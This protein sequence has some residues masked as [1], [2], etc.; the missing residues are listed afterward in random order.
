MK[1]ETPNISDAEWEVMNVIWNT[2]PITSAEVVSEVSKKKQW[3]VKTIKTLLNRLINKGALTYENSKN[4]YLYRPVYPRGD[5]VKKESRT[6]LDR[7]FDGAASHLLVHF[8]K[9]NKLSA[10]EIK[11]LRKILTEK[12]F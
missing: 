11:E 7:V 12:E 9:N 5:Y 10:D 6:F 8:V 1:K 2:N 3:T 4:A